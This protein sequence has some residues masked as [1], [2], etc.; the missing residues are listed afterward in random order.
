MIQPRGAVQQLQ[1]RGQFHRKTPFV[2]TS[3]RDRSDARFDGWPPGHQPPG[4][5]LDDEQSHATLGRF[6]QPFLQAFSICG[7]QLVEHVAGNDRRR[8]PNRLRPR[9]ITLPGAS[10][11]TEHSIGPPCFRDGPGMP[12]DTRD[13]RRSAAGHR[14]RCSRCPCSTAEIENP[15]RRRSVR[16]EGAHDEIRREKVKRRVEERESGPLARAVERAVHPGLAA[17]DIGR[18]QRAER[19]RDLRDAEIREVSRLESGQ[20]AAECWRIFDVQCRQSV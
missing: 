7:W 1:R 10:V 13:R 18:R 9:D 16:L 14:P 17:L 2:R 3:T 11:D 15:R 4:D 12:I 5:G 6:D 20:P 8:T 19:A